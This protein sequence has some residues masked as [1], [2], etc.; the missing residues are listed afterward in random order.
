MLDASNYIPYKRL[1]CAVIEQEYYDYINDIE[2]QDAFYHFCKT[3][4]WFELLNIDGLEFYDKA[5]VK[6]RAIKNGE[7]KMTRMIVKR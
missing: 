1:A 6:K 2:N 3:C 5:V 7:K 4:L